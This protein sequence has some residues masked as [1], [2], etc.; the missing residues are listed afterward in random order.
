M[1][2]V[3]ETFSKLGNKI[4]GSLYGCYGYDEFSKFLAVLSLVF[5]ILS[6]FVFRWF[7]FI[8]AVALYFYMF[9][10]V[11][12]KDGYKR[13][14]ENYKYLTV[15]NKIKGSFKLV[16]RRF[17]ERKTHRYYKCEGCKAVLRVP[18]G[19]GKIEITC[20]KCGRKTIKET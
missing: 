13:S 15:R 1:S 5:I 20:P 3:K 10:R 8:A 9:Y 4:K 6:L 2:K 17:S 18:K 16:K 19:K 11:F 14:G 7:F 12:A